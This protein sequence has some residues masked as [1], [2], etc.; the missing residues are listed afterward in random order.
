MER[1]RDGKIPKEKF[2]L[3]KSFVNS[4][5]G[6]LIDKWFHIALQNGVKY[7]VFGAYRFPLYPTPIFKILA[8]KSLRELVLNECDLMHYVS[9]FSCVTNCKSLR[10]LSLNKVVECQSLKSLDLSYVTMSDGFLHSLISRFQSLE[11]DISNLVSL[12]YIGDQIPQ[13][14]MARELRQLKHSKIVLTFGNNDINATWFCKLRKL[15]SNL[16]SWS[17]VSL[18][19]SECNEITMKKLQRNHTVATPHVDVL[20]VNILCPTFMD[21]LLWSCHPRRLYLQSTAKIKKCFID[22]LMHLKNSRHS[23]SHGSKP[24]YSQL[25]DIKAF[26]GKNQPFELRSGELAIKTLMEGENVY[27]L[28]DW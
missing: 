17:Q 26:D 2:E 4:E 10:N 27:F 12:V 18:Y 16:T 1:Y 20:N 13:L 19:F 14:K 3:S 24:R 11:I 25:K 5:V 23:T 15:L 9:L 6:R 21:A 28:L 7:F 8:A 22:H